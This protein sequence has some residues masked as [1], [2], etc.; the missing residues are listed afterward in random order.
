[1]PG[2]DVS[3]VPVGRTSSSP[4]LVPS[5]AYLKGI[6]DQTWSDKTVVISLQIFLIIIGMITMSKEQRSNKESK[7]KPAMT[8]KEKKAAKK[9]KKESRGLFIQ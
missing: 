2:F 6:L 1:L 5:K 8:A 9:T 7:K 4:S 3:Y